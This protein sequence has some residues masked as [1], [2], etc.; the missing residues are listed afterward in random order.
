M[1]LGP[2]L[3][4]QVLLLGDARPLQLGFVSSCQKLPTQH[5]ASVLSLA[6]LR[7]LQ[8]RVHLLRSPACQRQALKQ[9]EL[10]ELV[11][12]QPPWAPLLE[13]RPELGLV[14]RGLWSSAVQRPTGR[15]YH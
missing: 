10:H 12:Q 11:E 13:L 4:V 14:L 8:L 6:Q 3:R 2:S 9:E 5:E 15:G 7:V 1:V